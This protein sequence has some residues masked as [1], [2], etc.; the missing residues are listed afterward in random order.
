[1]FNGEQRI[2]MVSP[3]VFIVLRTSPD[4]EQHILTMTNV[5]AEVIRVSIPL[6]EIELEW[7]NWYD[8]VG[9]RGWRA[10]DKALMVTLQP[11]DVVWLI[12]FAELERMIE[13]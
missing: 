5:T 11:Y 4:C 6:S 7:K 2:L 3:G 13:S 12:P 8:L 1:M 9:K 10:K